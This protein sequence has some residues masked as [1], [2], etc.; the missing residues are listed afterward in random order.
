M[1]LDFLNLFRIKYSK[2]N[3][4]SGHLSSIQLSVQYDIISSHFVVNAL[5]VSFMHFYTF[6]FID[7]I[8]KTLLFVSEVMMYVLLLIVFSPMIHGEV[9][10]GLVE[11]EIFFVLGII[12][13]L[14]TLHDGLFA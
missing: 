14:H 5:Y 4:N 3:V 6:T 11:K 1:F 13:L 7:T 10:V 12:G 8:N 9:R 2:K